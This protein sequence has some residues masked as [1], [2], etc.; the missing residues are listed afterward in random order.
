MKAINSKDGF[1][2]QIVRYGVDND[3]PQQQ[4]ADAL[5]LLG[6]VSKNNIKLSASHISNFERK[7]LGIR[8]VA[9]YTKPNYHH[10]NHITSNKL[11]AA[12]LFSLKTKIENGEDLTA[13]EIK[14]ADEAGISGILLRISERYRSIMAK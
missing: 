4:V 5:S 12:G 9:M 14:Q 3:I 1:C 11:T 8:R 6:Y 10:M 2:T 7:D 13:A